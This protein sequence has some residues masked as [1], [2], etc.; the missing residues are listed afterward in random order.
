[1]V[2]VGRVVSE[3]LFE[4]VDARRRSLS[5]LLAVP[6]PFA[7]VN[8]LQKKKR[9]QPC[10]KNL[11]TRLLIRVFSDVEKPFLF[12][13]LAALTAKSENNVGFCR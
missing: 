7:K 4:I 13:Y 8:E 12:S 10:Q 6:E 1:M 9:R 11:F 5:I 2:A 3:K